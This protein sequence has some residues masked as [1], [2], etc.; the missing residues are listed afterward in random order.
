VREIDIKPG[1]LAFKANVWS[2]RACNIWCVVGTL[3]AHA[4]ACR[5]TSS[6]KKVRSIKIIT[7]S[8]AE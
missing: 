3:H 4:H 1:G 7:D 8:G 6:L 5:T 2:G